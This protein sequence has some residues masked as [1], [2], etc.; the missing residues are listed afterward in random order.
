MSRLRTL[1]LVTAAV[2][3]AAAATAALPAR[4]PRPAETRADPDVA[5]AAAVLCGRIAADRPDGRAAS[6]LARRAADRLAAARG[7]D[8]PAAGLRAAIIVEASRRCPDVLA[9][10]G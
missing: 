4:T 9:R 1:A 2:A 6:D 5:A 7:P 8:T 10:L 3:L